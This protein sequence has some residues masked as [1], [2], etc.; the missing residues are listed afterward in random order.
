V[1]QHCEGIYNHALLQKYLHHLSVVIA[2][3]MT[4]TWRSKESSL[5]ASVASAERHITRP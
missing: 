4:L 3:G 2:T 1:S 5:P